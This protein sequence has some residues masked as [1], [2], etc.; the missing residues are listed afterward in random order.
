[1]IDCSGKETGIEVGDVMLF[2]VSH[3]QGRIIS[4]IQRGDAPLQWRN[5]TTPPAEECE[6]D[7]IMSGTELSRIAMF[8]ARMCG[9]AGVQR[10][11]IKPEFSSRGWIGFQAV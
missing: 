6:V 9:C 8:M 7:G 3:R 10:V 2:R 4:R 11:S 1:M 5:H